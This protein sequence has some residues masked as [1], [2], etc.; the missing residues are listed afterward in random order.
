LCST[1][2]SIFDEATTHRSV[3]NMVSQCVGK[4]DCR[5]RERIVDAEQPCQ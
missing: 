5:R 1:L 2:G 4:N 3:A